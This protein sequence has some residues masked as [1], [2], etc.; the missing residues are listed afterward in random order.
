M[1]NPAVMLFPIQFSLVR[2]QGNGGAGGEI[3]LPAS[4]QYKWGWGK[5]STM[6]IDNVLD[7]RATRSCG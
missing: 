4:A 6:L 3:P 1:E 7:Y 2:F 5:V